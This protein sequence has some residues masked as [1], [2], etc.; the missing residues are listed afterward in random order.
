MLGSFSQV[1]FLLQCSRRM[2]YHG[3]YKTSNCK[4]E[5]KEMSLCEKGKL[6][7]KKTEVKGRKA[8]YTKG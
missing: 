2:I 7:T 8:V 3:I 4:N 6:P 1:Y 5:K